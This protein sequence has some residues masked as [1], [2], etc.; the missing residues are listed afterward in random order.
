MLPNSS[1][2]IV[3]RG[4]GSKI[5]TI[6]IQHANGWADFL[7]LVVLPLIFL[8]YQERYRNN[9]PCSIFPSNTTY[10]PP[11]LSEHVPFVLHP[12]AGAPSDDQLKSVHAAWRFS[13][14][15][16]P[17]PSMFDP[18][19][20]MRLSQHLFDIQFE[21]YLRN[22]GGN[23]RLAQA[24]HPQA[25]QPHLKDSGEDHCQSHELQG[26]PG[27]IEPELDHS[28]TQ[29]TT[30]E[31]LQDLTSTPEPVAQGTVGSPASPR[32][33][34]ESDSGEPVKPELEDTNKLLV[35]IEGVLEIIS[36]ILISTQHSMARARSMSQHHSHT[37]INAH[38]D[39][40]E[41]GGLPG[42]RSLM[43]N[44]EK[45]GSEMDATLAQYLEFYGIGSEC[46]EGGSEPMIK[47]GKRAEAKARLRGYLNL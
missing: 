3:R 8:A 27:A 22:T 2:E 28:A 38:G 39:D 14:S 34:P 11:V 17:V 19:L 6:S 46:I 15:L 23:N 43:R 21:R 47:E 42:P 31:P 12:V 4:F 25:E 9:Y 7:C 29:V 24:T 45:W 30:K 5:I 44:L 20:N 1:P 18:D 36:R 41:R 13:E 32:P 33:E 26:S 35:K 37:F 40:P 16:A 10:T